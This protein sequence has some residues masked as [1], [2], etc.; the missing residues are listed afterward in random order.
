MGFFAIFNVMIRL[1]L[2]KNSGI[3]PINQVV[4]TTNY[5]YM[6]DFPKYGF[7]FDKLLFWINLSGS[8]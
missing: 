7:A 2:D 8:G 5:I 3:K 6:I 4:G 1:L